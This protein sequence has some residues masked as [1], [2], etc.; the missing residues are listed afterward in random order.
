MATI[1]I[2][3]AKSIDFAMVPDIRL[4]DNCWNIHLFGLESVFV[5]RGTRLVIANPKEKDPPVSQRTPLVRRVAGLP[6]EL[7]EMKRRVLYINGSPV[8]AGGAS[9]TYRFTLSHSPDQEFLDLYAISV[10]QET[11]L[12]LCYDAVLQEDILSSFQKD[13]R[14]SQC[15]MLDDPARYKDVVLYP[16]SMTNTW[17]LNDYGPYLIPAAG[18]KIELNPE[19]LEK[20]RHLL[21]N[22]EG[23]KLQMINQ[24]ITVDGKPSGFYTFKNDYY[25]VLSDNRD[26]GNDS[27]TFGPVP[28]SLFQGI[29]IF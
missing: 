15:R 8:S 12:P 21:E 26:F 4:H 10:L 9:F 18:T 24:Q 13:K 1:V 5:D 11:A 14:V 3:R 20:Y 6:G 17:T 28:V 2:K 16:F 19:N 27:R 23:I 22:Y 25:F 7:V 29:L